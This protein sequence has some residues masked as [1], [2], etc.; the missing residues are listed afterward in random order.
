MIFWMINGFMWLPFLTT[1]MAQPTN[2]SS[3]VLARSYRKRRAA[4]LPTSP[5]KNILSPGSSV[6]T[7]S[8]MTFEFI[9]KRSR[10]RRWTNSLPAGP[11][12]SLSRLRFCWSALALSVS[13]LQGAAAGPDFS[14]IAYPAAVPRGRRFLCSIFA[15]A[16]RSR[17]AAL[18][19]SYRQ[20]SAGATWV[21]MDS[22]TCAL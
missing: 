8:S 4:N 1:A 15:G 17:P 20:P 10:P 22:M 9:T 21:R 2:C 13:V 19:R 6:S 12:R 5:R 16:I 18:R 11:H 14:D 7:A 3:M